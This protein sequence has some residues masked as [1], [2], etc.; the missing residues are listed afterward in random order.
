VIEQGI[1]RTKFLGHPDVSERQL[2]A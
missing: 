1:E 2:G